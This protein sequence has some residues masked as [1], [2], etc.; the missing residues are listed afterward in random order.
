VG[1]NG[2]D[3]W[4]VIHGLY[5][6]DF[7]V[8]RDVLPSQYTVVW[9]KAEQVGSY[10]I[11]CSQYCGT[12]H[13]QMVRYVRVMNEVD[14]QKAMIAAQGAGLTPA[15]LGKKVFEGKGACASCHDTTSERK[16]VVGPPL[17]AAYG[18]KVNVVLSNG[19]SKTLDFDDNYIRQSIIDPNFRSVVGYP[20]VMPSYQGQ[21]S[22]KEVTALTEYIKS[23]KK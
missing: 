6:P 17:Y 14:Y 11:L 5:I 18:E 20:S 22:D 16:R 2:L 9:F 4:H 21:L 7:R 10:P 3:F 19:S 13:S 23:L 8:N 12:K 1:I 15:Q